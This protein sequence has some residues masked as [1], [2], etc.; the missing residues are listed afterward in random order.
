[1]PRAP[2]RLVTPSRL[3][4]GLV[5]PSRLAAGRVRLFSGTLAASTRLFS[6]AVAASTPPT[7]IRMVLNAV[8]DDPL[9]ALHTNLVAEEQPFPDPSTLASDAVVVGVRSCAVH[10]VDLLM[11]LI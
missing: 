4:M 1:M 10:W 5:T 7:G 2:S 6:G 11:M 3:A 9:T 8:S